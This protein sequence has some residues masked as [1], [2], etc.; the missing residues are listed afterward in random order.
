MSPS[1]RVLCDALIRLAKGML[2]ACDKWIKS[3]GEHKDA[4]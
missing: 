3:Q 4:A 1:T 2:D